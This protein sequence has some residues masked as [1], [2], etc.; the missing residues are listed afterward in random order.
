MRNVIYKCN[1]LWRNRYI[2]DAMLI[3]DADPDVPGRTQDNQ[4]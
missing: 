3:I 4:T 2:G 1:N